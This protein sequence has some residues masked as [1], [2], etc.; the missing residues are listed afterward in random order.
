MILV[1][2]DL[3]SWDLNDHVYY[4]KF[5]QKEGIIKLYIRRYIYSILAELSGNEVLL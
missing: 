2:Y 1:H 4:L 3:L 5:F